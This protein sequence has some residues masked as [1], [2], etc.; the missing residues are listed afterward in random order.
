LGPLSGAQTI[1]WDGLDSSGQTVPEGAY[2]VEVEAIGPDGENIDVLQSAMARVTGVE[3]SPE[4]ITYL[5]LKNGLRLS[6]GE[7]ES[8]MEG[9]VQP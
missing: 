6:L 4:G 8:I 9:G 2:R 7:I 5:V 1:T 3:F